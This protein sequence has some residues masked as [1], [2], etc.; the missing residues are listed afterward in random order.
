M[1]LVTLIGHLGKDPELRF[2]QTGRAVCSFSMATNESYKSG[3]EWKQDKQWHNIVVWGKQAEY[4][5][6]NL[7]KGHKVF[8]HGKIQTRSYDDKNGN[9]RY[10][11]EIV[12]A[13]VEHFQGVP[14]S[15]GETAGGAGA[16]LSDDDI[17][18]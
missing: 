5:G 2:T 1:N 8:V 14:T 18:F 3:D 9:K 4:C 16:P 6:G 13:K 12:A 7:L 15:N 17:P 11:T 10:I